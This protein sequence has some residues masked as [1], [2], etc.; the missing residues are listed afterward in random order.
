MRTQPTLWIDAVVA[1]FIGLFASMVTTWFPGIVSLPVRIL[2]VV[3]FAIVMW[4]AMLGVQRRRRRT[5]EN[6]VLDGQS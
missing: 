1:I 2:L 5:F 4:A 6:A 3:S